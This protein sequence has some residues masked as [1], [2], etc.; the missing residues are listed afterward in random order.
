MGNGGKLE[1]KQLEVCINF[2]RVLSHHTCLVWLKQTQV[3]SPGWYGSGTLVR[4]NNRK[5]M[6][7]KG[8]SRCSSERTLVQFVCGVKTNEPT[9]GFYDCRYVIL[10]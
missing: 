7:W 1:I 6:A 9:T 2:L 10:S 8:G 5:K 3:S 4:T